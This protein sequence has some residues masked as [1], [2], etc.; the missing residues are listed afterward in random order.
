MKREWKRPAVLLA[1]ALA[2]T[3]IVAT[4]AHATSIR[5]STSFENPPFTTGAIA[6]Q[7]GWNKFGPGLSTVENIFAKTGAQAVGLNGGAASQTGPWHGDLSAGPLVELSADLAI[8]T[9]STQTSWQFGATG[10][11]LIQYLGGIDVTENNDILLITAGFPVVG[12][13]PRAAPFDPAGWHHIDAL[14]NIGTQRYDISLDGVL[15][16]TNIPFCGSNAGCTGAAVANYGSGIF[17]GF[18]GVAGG[19]DV[20]FMDNFQVANVTAAVPEPSSLALLGIGLISARAARW[21]KQRDT[22]RSAR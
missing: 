18:G 2:F 7:D 19:N 21:R 15:L 14:F 11:N 9:S 4:P 3:A 5:Y 12:K 13:F 16:G 1:H 8:F 17:D 20:A 10:P 22:R 6:G